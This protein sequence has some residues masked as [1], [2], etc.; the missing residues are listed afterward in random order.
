MP[1]QKA[2]PLRSLRFSPDTFLRFLAT[3][4]LH[5]FLPSCR[6]PAQP[7]TGRPERES[8]ESMGLD[9]LFEPG[10]SVSCPEPQVITIQLGAVRSWAPVCAVL[11]RFALMSALPVHVPEST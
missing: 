6:L 2:E 7:F 5:T 10:H 11:L 9:Y 1:A 3:F 8:A 4:I